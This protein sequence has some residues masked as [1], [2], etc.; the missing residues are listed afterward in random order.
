M[1]LCTV[2]DANISQHKKWNKHG[3]TCRNPYGPFVKCAYKKFNGISE[4]GTIDTIVLTCKITLGFWSHS[5]IL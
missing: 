4:M 5:D 2:M 3:S 1:I